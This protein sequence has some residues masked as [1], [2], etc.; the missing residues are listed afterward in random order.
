MQVGNNN[1]KKYHAAINQNKAARLYQ[2]EQ[3]RI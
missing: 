2:L 1:M 3:T